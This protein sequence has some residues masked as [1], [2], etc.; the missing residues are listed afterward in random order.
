MT[1]TV[2]TMSSAT[3]GKTIPPSTANHSKTAA[4]MSLATIVGLVIAGIGAPLLV[5]CGIML[6]IR[7]RRHRTVT[8]DGG[9]NEGQATSEAEP[10]HSSDPEPPVS[11]YT[12]QGGSPAS[13]P[14]P[15][16]QERSPVAQFPEV[17]MANLYVRT[18]RSFMRLALGPLG[19]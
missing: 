4:S 17:K 15:A 5:I 11:Q 3:Q 12:Q 18:N 10:V 16:P 7:R 19:L 13:Q 1:G 9:V 14:P 8:V 2:T 6:A